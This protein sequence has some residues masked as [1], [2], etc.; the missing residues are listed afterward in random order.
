MSSA[1]HPPKPP[2]RRRG[3]KGRSP[4]HLKR[5]APL[6]PSKGVEERELSKAVGGREEECW[7]QNYQRPPLRS[8]QMKERIQQF[9]CLEK[10]DR[11]K[12][13]RKEGLKKIPE[14]LPK[15]AMTFTPATE[16]AREPKAWTPKVEVSFTIKWQ[17]YQK[18]PLNPL[19]VFFYVHN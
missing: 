1:Q 17:H 5:R 3:G 13:E 15:P 12:V 8:S 2:S 14:K 11:V 10:A 6:P 16:P 9:S 4:K 18:Y 7:Y 19:K